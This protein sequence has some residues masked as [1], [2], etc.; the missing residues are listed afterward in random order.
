[1]VFPIMLLP[2]VWNSAVR[3]GQEACWVPTP[4]WAILT[5]QGWAS[6]SV[7]PM[8]TRALC[9]VGSPR[10]HEEGQRHGEHCCQNG[11]E[12]AVDPDP[13]S[14][15]MNYQTVPSSSDYVGH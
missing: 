6:V 15:V 9:Q 4:S 5:Q 1:M 3:P 10:T 2:W 7:V 12:Q 13:V 11:T 8:A 14:H